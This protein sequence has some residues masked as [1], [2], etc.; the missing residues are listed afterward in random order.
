M[1]VCLHWTKIYFQW[2]SA[3]MDTSNKQCSSRVH[4]GT[5]KFNF[6][7]DDA[8]NGTECL[9]SKFAHHTKLIW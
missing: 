2:F 7:T 8:G 4:V 3:Q 6:F 5:N 9:L 1:S